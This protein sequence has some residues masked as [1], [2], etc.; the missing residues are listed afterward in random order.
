M[1]VGGVLDVINT[2]LPPSRGA[3]GGSMCGRS[4]GSGC[5][6]LSGLLLLGQPK[7]VNHSLHPV[8][9]DWNFL[10][11][12]VCYCDQ[13]FG[14]PINADRGP[15]VPVRAGA[16]EA[17]LVVISFISIRRRCPSTWELY[18]L[19]RQKTINISVSL[20]VSNAH[21]STL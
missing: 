4:C 18:M 1:P 16:G 14:L 15:G 6:G 9:W 5:P 7:F 8:V 20:C 21:R 2:P 10:A 17:K 19:G 3:G 12:I 11:H 13:S